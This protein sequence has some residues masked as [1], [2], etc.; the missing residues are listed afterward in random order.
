MKILIALGGNALLSP[1]QQ[2]TIQQQLET[3]SST[4]KEIVKIIKAGHKV[5][6]STGN[7][8]QIGF[9]AIQNE[10]S[11]GEVPPMPLDVL[12]AE[13]QGWIGYLLQKQLGIELR[14]NK[15]EIPVL[16]VITQVLVD[17]HDPEF[18][19]PTKPIGPYYSKREADRLAKERNWMFKKLSKGYRRVV[20]SPDPKEIV[21]REVIKKLVDSGAIVIACSG[22]GIPVIKKN[23]ELK[24]VEAVI[25]KDL[26]SELLATLIGAEMFLILTDVDQVYLNYGQPNQ[27]PISH[28]TIG[29]ARD[30]LNQGQFPPGSMGPK[31]KACIRFLEH[32]GQKAVITSLNKANL[33]L[34]GKAGTL[35]ER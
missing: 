30:Y 32:G 35:I 26:A 14:R 17:Q 16:T 4:C 13:S 18:Q 25:D 8:S 20:S 27:K 31:I 2:G 21:E 22:G 23:G 6:L 9:L 10:I 15:L 7:G 19:N 11:K 12:G 28:L 3:V 24:G 1:D 5:T 33:A 34:E 29:E